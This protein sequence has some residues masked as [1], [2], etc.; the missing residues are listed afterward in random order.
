[1][2]KNGK[3]FDFNIFRRLGDFIRSIYFDDISLEQAIEKQNEMEYLL[4]NLEACKPRNSDNIKSKEEVCENAGIFIQD[5]D[6][7]V[8]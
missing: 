2:H 5:R 6:L 8:I 1:M 4:R 3:I 7:V